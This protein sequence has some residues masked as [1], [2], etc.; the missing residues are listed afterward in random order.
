[1]RICICIMDKEMRK[2]VEKWAGGTV[3]WEGLMLE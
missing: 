3:G 1:M 2:L